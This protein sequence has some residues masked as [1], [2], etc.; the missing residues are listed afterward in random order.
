MM[1]RRNTLIAL[2]AA[3]TTAGGAAVT[4]RK[5]MYRKM[6][7]WTEL[8]SFSAVPPLLP[9]D[10]ARDR[11]VLSVARGGTPEAK[12]DSVLDKLGGMRKIVGADDVVIIKVAAQWWN[13]GMT[14]VAAAKR[15]IEQVLAVP[16]FKG[17]VVVFENTHFLLPDGSAG[18]PARG[19]TRAWMHPSVRNVDV[20]G[21][22]KLGDL[23]PHFRRLG[24]PVSFVGLADAGP[25]ALAGDHWWD[26][27]HAHGVYG[28]DG[29][30][31]IE[32]GDTR[33]GYFWSFEEAF[34][35]ARSRVDDA[36][37]PLTW[38]RFTCPRTGLVID[39][40]NGVFRRENGRL[41]ATGRRLRFLNVTTGNEHGSTGFTGA[42][43][44]AMGIVDM[45]AG[46]MGTHPAIRDYQSVHHFGAFGRKRPTWRMAGPLAHFAQRVR[47]PDLYITVSEWTAYAPKTGYNE[48][49]DD[50]RLSE[51]TIAR[52]DTVVAGADP[53]A[54]D[55]WCVRNLLMP[56]KGAGEAM[57]DLD[58]PES[59]ISCFLRYYRQTAGWG[60]LDPSMVQIL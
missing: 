2:A 33:D 24:A 41:A 30:G 22:D 29:R 43:K 59:K 40:R 27:E 48:E 28:G 5:R 51:K 19:L 47:K 17:S 45:S 57:H 54:I 12:I 46:T 9:H 8:D 32:A 58:R 60:T 39:F 52:T 21:W 56:L 44:S 36:Q 38:P 14:N 42:C 34:R 55:S 20:P 50:I 26:P 49:E 53:V 1:T 37:T 16:G 10:P 6:A 15:V 23:V 35:L 25:S 7:Q 31:P 11:T 18:D 13:Q 3:A 4:V